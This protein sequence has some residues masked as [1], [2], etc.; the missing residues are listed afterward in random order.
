MA[1]SGWQ[2][3]K[4]FPYSSSDLKC[5][6]YISSITHTGTS[7]RVQGK[8]GAVCVNNSAGWYAWYDYPVYVTPEGGSQQTLLAANEKVYGDGQGGLSRAKTVDFDVTLTIGAADTSHNFGV[9][10]TMNNGQNTGTLR[11]NIT[12][13]SGG[14]APTGLNVTNVSPSEQSV[15]ATVSVTGWGGLGSSSTRYRE[16]QVWQSNMAGLRRY[17]Q[18]SGDTLSGTITCNN[19]SQGTLNILGNT[20]YWIGGYATNGTLASGPTGFGTTITRPPSAMG[21]VGTVTKNSAVINW[22]IANQGG[23][24]N[25]KVDYS[26]NGGT[27]WNDITTITTS[28]AKNG[29]ITITGLLPNKSY[30]CTLRSA[31]VG[32]ATVGGQILNFTTPDVTAKVYCSVNDTAKRV[33]ESYCSV[34]GTAKRIKKVYCSVNGVA[35]LGYEDPN[36]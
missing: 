15:T 21:S 8:V 19:S 22:S 13:A 14:T 3:N 2:G 31:A 18:V 4:D 25:I 11:W 16:L 34:G 1:S 27:T 17:Q 6:L 30:Q 29:S 5:N 10:I 9:Y 32:G 20:K 35:K 7:L 28:G 36:L 26:L 24:K 23:E 33:K 12:F